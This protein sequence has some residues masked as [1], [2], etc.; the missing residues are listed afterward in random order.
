M[1]SGNDLAFAIPDQTQEG[2]ELG[3]KTDNS[4]RRLVRTAWIYHSNATIVRCEG[5]GISGWRKRA[6]MDPARRIV[7]IFTTHSVEREALPPYAA[8]WSFIN[9]FDEAGKDPG[10]CIG[11]SSPE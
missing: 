10:M 4:F 2:Q 11:R 6:S 1:T 3:T 7:Q 8:L 9:P 5:K